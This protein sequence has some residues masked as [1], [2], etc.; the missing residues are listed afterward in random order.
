M[1]DPKI[2]KRSNKDFLDFCDSSN[3]KTP[4]RLNTN[5]LKYVKNDLDPSHTLV[6]S[7]LLAIQ[8]FVGILTLLFC[9]QFNFSFTNNAEIFHYFHHKFG[10]QFCMAICGVIFIG[11]GSIFASYILKASEVNKIKK[12]EFLYYFS[13]TTI[14][15]S[16]FIILG[17]EVYLNL[18]FF[19]F[20]GA[21][22][23]GISLFEINRIIRRYCLSL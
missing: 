5:I 11:S 22:L 19:W 8:A 20:I 9:P 23:G 16:S 12:S 14:A 4:E 6:F 2:D 15:L 10:E 13:I 18:T 3:S 17:A 7:K 21:M 1:T